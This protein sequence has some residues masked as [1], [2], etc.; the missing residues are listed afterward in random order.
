MARCTMLLKETIDYY[1]LNKGHTYCIFLDATKAF[2]KVKYCK[3]FWC[4]IDRKIPS[5]ILHLL[6]KLYTSHVTR[7]IWNGVQFRWFNHL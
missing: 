2:D 6:Y 5:V 4:R 1:S 3:L 7:V